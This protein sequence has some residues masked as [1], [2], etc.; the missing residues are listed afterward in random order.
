MTTG[1]TDPL[2][3]RPFAEFPERS[4]GRHQEVLRVRRE[5][6]RG[7]QCDFGQGVFG[8]F[9]FHHPLYVLNGEN[10]RRGMIPIRCGNRVHVL[11]HKP[12]VPALYESAIL[13]PHWAFGMKSSPNCAGRVHPFE[14][15]WTPHSRP[16]STHQT[17]WIEVMYE[18]VSYTS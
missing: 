16:S 4:G 8:L 10:T 18:C 3:Q 7:Q 6:G 2:E 5:A 12:G 13:P 11:S 1:R 17:F 14:M 15:R 9:M